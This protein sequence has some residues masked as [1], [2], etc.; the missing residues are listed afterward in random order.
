M[1]EQDNTLNLLFRQL[2][3]IQSQA[4]RILS[5]EKSHEAI[6]NFAI[7][8]AELKNYIAENI[9]D[10]NIKHFLTQIPDINHS[11]HEIKL[12]Q[13]LVFYGLISVCKNLIA[14]EKSISEIG[15]VKEKYTNL[16][17][18]LKSVSRVN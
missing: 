1:G 12:W 5:G 9:D 16:E 15:I 2:K 10:E 7:Y 4:D 6:R 11:R 18:M 3:D 17:I 8:S 14:T 13:F